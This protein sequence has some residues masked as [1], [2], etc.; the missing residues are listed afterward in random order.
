MALV[1]WII[2]AINFVLL[3]IVLRE[4]LRVARLAVPI[5]VCLRTGETQCV[6]A[7]EPELLCVQCR[8]RLAERLARV[9][10]A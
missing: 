2:P 9:H 3:V 4:M 10:H 1:L 7:A 5:A 8:A 6:I